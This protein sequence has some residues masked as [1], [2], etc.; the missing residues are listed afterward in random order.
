MHL[1]IENDFLFYRFMTSGCRR[2]DR[3]VQL[4]GG[5]KIDIFTKKNAKY[6]GI[7]TFLTFNLKPRYYKYIRFRT[8]SPK[9]LI[10]LTRS[11]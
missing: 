2:N 7:E 6:F 4:P 10:I 5:N 3:K 1:Q 11:S 8:I 9:L